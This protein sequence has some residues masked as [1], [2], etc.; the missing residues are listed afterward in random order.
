V[1]GSYA[2][3]NDD[4]RRWVDLDGKIVPQWSFKFEIVDVYEG[5]KYDDTVISEIYFSGPCH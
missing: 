3:Y 2:I 5:T 4:E 1:F